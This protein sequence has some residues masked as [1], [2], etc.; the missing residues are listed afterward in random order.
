MDKVVEEYKDIFTSP[1]GVPLHCQ[2]KH[3]IDMTPGASLPNGP[4]YRHSI[5]E[6]D[7]IKRQIQELLHKAKIQVILDWPSPTTLTE[8][9]SFLGL[10]NLYSKF[11]LG[12]SHI[13]W[14]L[15]QVTKGGAKAKFFWSESQQKAFTE[16]KHH[17]CLAPVL[18]LPDLQQP[19]EV[20]TDA[21]NYAIGALLTQYEH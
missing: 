1:A 21:S 20:K 11:V 8:L 3:S 15:S 14:P 17:L 16:L 7:E 4:I 13:T 6:N 18:S 2:V 12:F 9:R 10:S 5:L 19:F